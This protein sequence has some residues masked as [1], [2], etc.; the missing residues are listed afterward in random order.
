MAKNAIV[1]TITV[2]EQNNVCVAI[3]SNNLGAYDHLKSIIPGSLQ[4]RL[5]SYSTV[6]RAVQESGKHLDIPTP[7][8]IF[9]IR[10]CPLYRFHT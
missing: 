9:V 7:L 10:K 4:Y 2:L 5:I 3:Y 8:G 6:N 1:R